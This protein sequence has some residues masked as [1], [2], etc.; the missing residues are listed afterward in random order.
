MEQQIIKIIA[1]ILQTTEH[2]LRQ[3]LDSEVLWDSLKK[4]EIILAMEEEFD[5]LFSQ[6][7]ILQI[8]NISSIIKLIGQKI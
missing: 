3:H 8:T 2:E 4:I 7:E 1:D 6:D 5:V